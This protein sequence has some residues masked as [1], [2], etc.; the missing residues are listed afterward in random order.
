MERL[1]LDKTD[2][3][4]LATLA[5]DC[6]ISYSSIG[7]QTG[8][9]SKSVKSR[10]MNMMRSG[11]IEKFVVRVNP[12]S[13]GY[14]TAH[15]L[16]MRNNRIAKEDVIE[17]IK[18]FGDLAYHVHHMGKTSMAAVIIK[19]SVSNKFV[20]SLNDFLN[21]AVVKRISVSEL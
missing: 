21:P 1:L 11:I 18:Q 14:R 7:S 9:T 6:R 13:F 8:L 15:V 3:N 19:E 17:R 5:R 16:V 20:Q 2:L 12:T 10:V 4:I